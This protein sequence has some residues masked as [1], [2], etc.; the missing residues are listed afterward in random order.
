MAASATSVNFYLGNALAGT[1]SVGALAPG[2]STTVSANIGPKDAGSYSAAAKVDENNTV[3]ETDNSNNGF[4]S[5][6]PLVVGQVQSSDLIGTASWTPGN[7]SAGNTVTFTVN[8]K[9]REI[10]LPRAALTA[11]P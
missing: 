3:I 11:S 1:A 6:S 4:A 9:I 2:A 10:P 7:P 5:S 8:L